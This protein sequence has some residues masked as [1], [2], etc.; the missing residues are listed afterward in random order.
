MSDF[1]SC[2]QDLANAMSFAPEPLI[3]VGTNGVLYLTV[4]CVPTDEGMDW[5]DQAVMYCPFCGTQLQTTE[6]VT[7]RSGALE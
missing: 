1:G 7:S 2:C 5:F 3:C 4:G 6:E